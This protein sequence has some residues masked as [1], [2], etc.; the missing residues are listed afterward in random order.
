MSSEPLV[1]LQGVV[2]YLSRISLPTGCRL[3]VTLSDSSLADVPATVIDARETQITQQVPL[4]FELGYAAGSKRSEDQGH[5]SE[6]L[7][8]LRCK[9]FHQRRVFNAP[10][11]FLLLHT[12]S[13]PS[14]LNSTVSFQASGGYRKFLIRLI[15]YPLLTRTLSC[16]AF[17]SPSLVYAPVCCCRPTSSPCR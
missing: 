5:S 1:R 8:V 10:L 7:I 16:L 13:F 3:T 12:A 2:Y 9:G 15:P 6:R 17:R 11:L 4:P 14:A